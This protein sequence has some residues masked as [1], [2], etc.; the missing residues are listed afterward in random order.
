MVIARERVSE[1]GDDLSSLSDLG[2]AQPWLA[3]P[4]TIA[5]LALA[6]F[7]LTGGF[8]GKF[9]LIDASVSG[10]Y[11]VLGIAIVVGSIISLGYYL[12]VIAEMWLGSVDVQLPTLPARRARPVGGWS[13]EA[14][15]RAQPEVTFV[16]VLCAVAIVAAFVYPDPLFDAAR[17]VGT[18][19]S[20][21]R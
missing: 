15:A 2:R 4:M 9:Y 19:L 21:L 20:N 16:A 6:G 18:S 10:D 3:W 13:P 17:D 14:D 11:T 5:M 12:R 7:P 8:T 1:H